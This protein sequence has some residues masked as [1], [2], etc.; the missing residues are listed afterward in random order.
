MALVKRPHTYT[1]GANTSATEATSNETTLYNLVNGLLD[2]TNLSPT[3]G[4]LGTQ[5]ATITQAG[6]VS[7]TAI[8]SGDIAIV[9]TDTT[10]IPLS[11]TASSL[12]TGSLAYLYS[13][14]AD[15]SSRNLVSIIN[16]N[17]LA[18]GTS[19]LYIKQDSNA[20]A[21]N[22]TSSIT[23]DQVVYI[24]GSS[25]TT[26]IG[27]YVYSNSDD[28]NARY[29]VAINNDHA[30]ADAA[31]CLKIYQ[32]GAGAQIL[33]MG[34]ENLSNAGVWTDRTCTYADK[35]DISPL[36]IEG[37]IEKL[38]N[39][40]L[41][42][43]KKKTEVEKRKNPPRYKGFILDDP[44]TPEELVSRTDDGNYD[45]INNALG[46][47]FLLAVVKELIGRVEALEAK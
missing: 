31:V 18:T 9:S 30:D 28:T 6:K 22:I 45:G 11:I 23:T 26:G 33:G 42:N 27:L 20:K 39:L 25:L 43:Y 32:D 40:N 44:S 35:T 12:T 37:F 15:S 8:T 41:F 46:I 36:V 14:S 38:K 16:D 17:A 47:N 13:N 7:G 19:G 2:T 1:D 10:T 4:I 34:N 21:I 3:A 24:A 5:L 29:L